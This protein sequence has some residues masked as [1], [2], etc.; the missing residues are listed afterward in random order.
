M[1]GV[2]VKIENI[3]PIVELEFVMDQPGLYV[4]QGNAGAGKTTA[5]RTIQLVVDGRCDV[6]PTKRDG[7]NR[8]LADIAGKVVRITKTTRSEGELSVDGLGDLSIAELHTPKFLDAKTR[9]RHRITTLVRLAGVEANAE[10]FYPLL[11]GR[12]DFKEIVS[13]KLME[14]DDLVEMATRVKAEIEREARRIEDQARTAES[15][16]KAQ[17]TLAEGVDES[18]EH[19]EKTLARNLEDAVRAHSTVKEQRAAYLRT[20]KAADAA[21]ERLAQLPPGKSVAEAEAA[22]E[23]A[24]LVYTEAWER[25]NRLRQELQTA[26]SELNIRKVRQE[27]ARSELDAAKRDV[28]I[29]GELDA[30]IEAASGA[31]E[32]S[33]DDVD[34]AAEAVGAARRASETGLQVRQAIR[35]RGKAAE[36]LE[37][38]NALRDKSQRLRDAATDTMNVLTESIARIEECPL[39][40]RLSEDGDPRLVVA[41][42]R[43]EHEY[44]DELS[45]GERWDLIMRIASR[46]NR[47]IAFPQ[48]A[49]GELAPSLRDQLHETAKRHGAFVVTAL[50]TDGELRGVPYVSSAAKASAAE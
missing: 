45:G 22:L 32:T 12:A 35:A 13:T 44:F 39:R 20:V 4:L 27:A 47:L 25:V 40:V 30:A 41:T 34:D 37:K 2:D 15:D 14:T 23:G 10:L 49:F 33:E 43:S 48:E 19:D 17:Q 11:G 38:A 21:R 3:G 42:D 46:K 8:G 50:A 31:V 16:A 24:E 5:L 28:S 29:R 18:A 7:A 26:E 36:H 6:K 9:D 1:R